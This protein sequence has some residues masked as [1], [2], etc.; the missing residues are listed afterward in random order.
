[1]IT[2]IDNSHPIDSRV[3]S[4]KVEVTAPQPR[5]DPKAE[6]RPVQKS[7]EVS[8]DQVTLKSAGQQDCDT[9]R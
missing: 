3:D 7:G 9:D 5:P 1:M 4:G 2:P 8:E 6:T